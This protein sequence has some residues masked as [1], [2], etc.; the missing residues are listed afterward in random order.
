MSWKKSFILSDSSL[1]GLYMWKS[2][3]FKGIDK[4]AHFHFIYAFGRK[5]PKAHHLICMCAPWDL[6][7]T[8][9]MQN[10]NIYTRYTRTQTI[11]KK[12]PVVL[13]VQLNKTW[14]PVRP[15]RCQTYP[16]I[17]RH[18]K[19]HVTQSRSIE[20]KVSPFRCYTET[21][22]PQNDCVH[23]IQN[24]CGRKQREGGSA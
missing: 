20:D 14:K 5:W 23:N 18:E 12:H 21:I 24:T 9:F 11:C 6:C 8:H 17:I 4:S 15:R 22:A 3:D 19:Q 2:H 10:C 13:E 7:V 1:R 16:V